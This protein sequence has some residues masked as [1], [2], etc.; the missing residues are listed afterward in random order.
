MPRAG[1]GLAGCGGDGLG[2]DRLQ[3]SAPAA[4]VAGLVLREQAAEHACRCAGRRG[5]LRSGPRRRSG[6]PTWRDAD[7][8]F[9]TSKRRAFDGDGAVA[10]AQGAPLGAGERQPERCG[11]RAGPRDVGAGEE[12]GERRV[13]DLGMALAVVVVL[14]PRLRRLVEFGQGQVF[15]MPSSMAISR[16]SICPQ[17]VSCFPLTYGEYGSVV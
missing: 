15:D 10:L 8:G 3:G 12:A 14:D 11:I 4:G 16:P 17:K 9:G 2:R 13:V 6:P 7:T 5:G 1:G